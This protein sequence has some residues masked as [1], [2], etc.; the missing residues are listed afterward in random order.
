MKHVKSSRLFKIVYCLLN[1]ERVTAPELAKRFEVSLRTIYRDIDALSVAGVPIFATRGKG[2][3]IRLMEGYVLNKAMMS[4]EEQ[5]RLLMAVKSLSAATGEDD[6]GLLAKLG[7]LFRKDRQDWLEVDFSRW[8]QGGRGDERFGLLRTAILERQ[9]L[10]FGYAGTRGTAQRLVKPAKLCYKASAW[11]LQAYCMHK[12]AYRTFK[13]S[14]ISGLRATGERFEEALTP[15]PIE[16]TPYSA[17]PPVK[18]KFAPEAAFRVYDEFGGDSISVLEDGSL[19]VTTAMPTQDGWLVDYLMSFG[20]CAEVLWPAQLRSAL[21]A[22]ALC[23][24]ERYQKDLLVQIQNPTQD[25]RLSAVSWICSDE[26]RNSNAQEVHTMEEKFCQS[27]GMPLGNEASEYGTEMDGN[28]NHDYCR[29]CYK[30]GS[31][32]ADCTMEAM[33]E[34]CVPHMVQSV[35]GM[36]DDKAREMMRQFFPKL[37]RWAK[38]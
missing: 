18:L 32:T 30:E 27:C 13:L 15:P 16:P 5:S 37:K 6:G 7:A 28:P 36:T 25:V 26:E 34:F 23:V 33:I 3:G 2:G 20:G 24:Y 22:R 14:R 21:A 12:Q 38:V 9:M 8:G 4:E 19:L 11:Y 35:P 29:Y 17:Y 31:F 1:Q 10:A